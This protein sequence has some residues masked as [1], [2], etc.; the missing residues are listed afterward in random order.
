MVEQH[1][2]WGTMDAKGKQMIPPMYQFL[3]YEWM[4]TYPKL[5]LAQK[6]NLWGF[7]NLKGEE[8]LPLKYDY[9]YKDNY[10]YTLVKGDKVGLWNNRETEKCFIPAVYT[11]INKNTYYYEN[12]ILVYD[13]DTILFVDKEGNEYD[14]QVTEVRKID[15]FFGYPQRDNE[16]KIGDKY[17]RPNIESKRPPRKE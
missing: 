13:G 12:Y 7:I 2:L 4:Y 3:Q 17:Y 15:A 6:D 1:R 16:V 9:I 5:L 8:V 11:K 14:A 10:G